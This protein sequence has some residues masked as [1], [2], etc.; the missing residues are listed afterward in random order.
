MVLSKLQNTVTL[1]YIHVLQGEMYCIDDGPFFLS[2]ET[3]IDHYRR[4]VDGLPCRLIQPVPPPEPLTQYLLTSKSSQH[5]VSKEVSGPILL[6][7]FYR[8]GNMLEVRM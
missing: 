3:M 2:L 8:M 4:F 7:H 5:I 1:H 6:P